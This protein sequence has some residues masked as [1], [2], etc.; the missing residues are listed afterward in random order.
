MIAK[1]A[2]FIL[3]KNIYYFYEHKQHLRDKLRYMRDYH[4]F[5]Y[6]HNMDAQMEEVVNQARVIL[7]L[8][9]K[10]SKDEN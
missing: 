5:K 4:K 9:F 6:D 7:N 1:K 3:I 2:L 10:L 8:M